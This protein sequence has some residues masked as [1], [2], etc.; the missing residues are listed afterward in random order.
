MNTKSITITETRTYYVQKEITIQIPFDIK[1]GDIGDYLQENTDL[2]ED[3]IDDKF[4][5]LTR[6]DFHYGNEAFDD[7][8][9]ER[10]TMY[11]SE[12]ESG[13]LI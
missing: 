3:A 4:D 2:W 10:E 12:N 8:T 13:F 7:S 1:E 11:E 9:L 6:K 5:D